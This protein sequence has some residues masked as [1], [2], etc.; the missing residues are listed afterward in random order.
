MISRDNVTDDKKS[1]SYRSL[2]PFFQSSQFLHLMEGLDDHSYIRIP[3][4]DF[5]ENT[6]KGYLLVQITY[7]SGLLKYLTTRAIIWHG[8]FRNLNFQHQDFLTTL[9]NLRKALPWYTLFIQFRNLDYDEALAPAF[10]KAGYRFSDRLNLVKRINP[11][12]EAW[13]AL[14]D[15][16][17]RQIRK[18]KENGLEIV[19]NPMEEEILAFYQLLSGLYQRIK[20]P[21]PSV[22]FF[23]RFRRLCLSGDIK[24]FISLARFRNRVVGGIVCPYDDT[25]R[26]YEYYI[27]GLDKEMAL[28]HV[29][30]SV[31]ITW[32]GM[33]RGAEL[34]CTLFDFM[35]LG[36]PN[37]PYGVREFKLRFGGEVINP[38]RW[39]RVHNRPLYFVAELLYNLRLLPE[40][41]RMIF[42]K[43]RILL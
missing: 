31:A 23:I 30:P 28:Y 36:I 40:F 1:L 35:G 2:P 39:N 10:Q 7:R 25:G 17:K 11:I 3:I 13:N 22:A 15:S 5:D 16:R 27:C 18:S 41:L 9:K 38:G 42:G 20:K 26:V 43:R 37:R 29:Y 19:R 6:E 32:E 14:S 8:P 21:L 12:E 4:I 33:E 24:G 34:G